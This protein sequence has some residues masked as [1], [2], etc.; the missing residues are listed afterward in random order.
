MSTRNIILALYSVYALNYVLPLVTLPYLSHVLGPAGLG[1]IGYAQSIAQIMLVV[2][3][4]GFGMSSARK[5]AVNVDNPRELNRIYWSTTI[6]RAILGTLCTLALVGWSF[7]AHMSP[8]ER[9]ATLLGSLIIW[10]GVIVPGC[11]YEGT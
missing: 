8:A 9:H 4:F 1:V 10:G 2:V 3:D 7:S 5:V 11:F 6:A